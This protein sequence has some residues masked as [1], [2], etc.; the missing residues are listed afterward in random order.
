MMKVTVKALKGKPGYDFTLIAYEDF[1]PK[2]HER[3]VE[4]AADADEKKTG[5]KPAD[6]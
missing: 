4:P 5:K 1:D 3:F 2:R 6:E